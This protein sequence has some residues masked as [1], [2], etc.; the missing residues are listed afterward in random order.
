MSRYVNRNLKI[1]S[2]VGIIS[3]FIW[4]YLFYMAIADYGISNDEYKYIYLLLLLL[5]STIGL[6][7]SNKRGKKRF[8]VLLIQAFFYFVLHYF[9]GIGENGIYKDSFQIFILL[10]S[11]F[12]FGTCAYYEATVVERGKRMYSK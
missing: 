7:N 3:S 8:N 10:L 9:Y 1:V 2:V 11:A 5:V 12:L 6:I 4:A